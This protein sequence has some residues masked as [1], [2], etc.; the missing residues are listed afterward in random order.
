[1]HTISTTTLTD[2][3]TVKP[4]LPLCQTQ[5]QTGNCTALGTGSATPNLLAVKPRPTS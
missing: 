1:V 3:G 4:A 2:T 5:D